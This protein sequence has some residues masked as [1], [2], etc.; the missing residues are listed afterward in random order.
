LIT[1][2]TVTISGQQW[3]FEVYA[4]KQ[5]EGHKNLLSFW[6]IAFFGLIMT[7]TLC[8]GSLM[9]TGRKRFLQQLVIERSDELLESERKYYSTFDNAPIW[10]CDGCNGWLFY[11]C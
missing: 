9:S 11:R 1:Q 6:L 3:S 5:A 8:Y 2:S 7:S 4:S 10:G